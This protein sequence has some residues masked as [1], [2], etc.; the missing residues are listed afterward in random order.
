MN[1]IHP[2]QT[3]TG[4]KPGGRRG[5]N[6]QNAPRKKVNPLGEE[7]I[8][9]YMDSKFLTR[10]TNDQG[11]ILPRR[12]TGVSAYQQRK[13]AQAIKHARHLALIPFVAQDIA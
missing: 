9:D 12:I 8:I 10:F 13:I 2:M 4:N 5:Q 1:A 6:N 7:K 3:G 11:K